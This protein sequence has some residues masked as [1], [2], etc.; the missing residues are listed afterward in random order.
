[1]SKE[2][3]SFLIYVKL[4]FENFPDHIFYIHQ[5]IIFYWS[6][7]TNKIEKYQWHI[8]KE[9]RVMGNG[10]EIGECGGSSV[11]MHLKGET[12]KLIPSYKRIAGFLFVTFSKSKC[13]HHIDQYKRRKWVFSGDSKEAEIYI[14]IFSSIT[15]LLDT[16]DTVNLRS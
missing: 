7:G 6:T 15:G 14:F 16:P 9:R 11:D 10:K 5:Y 2:I 12:T 3:V 13:V 4:A 1:M 8:F